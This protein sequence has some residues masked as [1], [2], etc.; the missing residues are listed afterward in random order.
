MG[1]FLKSAFFIFLDYQ[2]MNVANNYFLSKYIIQTW[3]FF[4]RKIYI[5]FMI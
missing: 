2:R 3:T 1:F 5:S 4:E